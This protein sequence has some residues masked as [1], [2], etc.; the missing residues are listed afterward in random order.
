[1]STQSA[2]ACLLARVAQAALKQLRDP[3]LY[4]VP[5]PPD[6]PLGAAHIELLQRD[7]TTWID[8]PGSVARVF[9]ISRLVDSIQDDPE[10]VKTPDRSPGSLCDVFHGL[11][12]DVKFAPAPLGPEEQKRYEAALAL[13]YVERPF[14]RTPAYQDFCALRSD[15]ELKDVA[16]SALAVQRAHTTDPEAL[17]TL[18]AELSLLESLQKERRQALDALDR[19]HGFTS[20]EALIDAAERT[21]DRIPDAVLQAAKAPVLLKITDILGS[22]EAIACRFS[23]ASLTEDNWARLELTRADLEKYGVAT[24]TVEP[25]ELDESQIESIELEVQTLVCDRHWFWPGLFDNT[26]WTWATPSPVKVSNGGDLANDDGL[27]PAYVYALTF[28][29]NL[30]VRGRP[31]AGGPANEST[32]MRAFTGAGSDGQRARSLLMQAA[33]FKPTT[34]VATTPAP[35]ARGAAAPAARAIPVPAARSTPAPAARATPAPAARATAVP[36]ARGTSNP[37]VRATPSAAVARSVRPPVVTRRES[38]RP[39]SSGPTIARG[40]ASRPTV[41]RDHR[42]S[43]T[44]TN[45][46][47][48]LGLSPHSIKHALLRQSAINGRVVDENDRPV[49]MATLTLQ[50]PG[51]ARSAVSGSNG[52][53]SFTGLR[54]GKYPL[55]VRKAGYTPARSTVVVPSSRVHVVRLDE[56]DTCE[57]RVRLLETN[58]AGESPFTGSAKLTIRGPSG[59]R[60]ENVRGPEARLK[61]VEGATR[62]TVT[63]TEASRVVPSTASARLSSAPQVLTFRIERAPLLQNPEVQLLAVVCRRVQRCPSD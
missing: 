22:G 50:I 32:F 61:L 38:A 6:L 41:V 25:G 48:S 29:R 3:H 58:G 33:R 4:V 24:S 44:T 55:V 17:A 16:L 63:S 1:M 47:A 15:A 60:I 21:L 56:I 31:S 27:I 23:P 42:R 13:L 26:R 8:D 7:P 28:A 35:A 5:A 30:V 45:P 54:P 43:T 2:S 59:T 36:A 12:D 49:A 9:E 14:E 37:V 11:L 39:T 62:V 20:A 53:F 10:V 57:L 18:D 19:A 52:S 51:G 34:A 40:D 46:K